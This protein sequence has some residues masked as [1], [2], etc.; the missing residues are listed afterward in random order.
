MLHR[1]ALFVVILLSAVVI[2][3]VQCLTSNPSN[4]NDPR[5]RFFAGAN[6]CITCHKDIASSYL[7]TNHYKTSGETTHD[8]LKNFINASNNK[9]YY[10][11]SALVIL[12]EKTSRFYQTYKM[13]GN[14]LRSE[15]LDIA[16]GSAEKAQT[17]AYWKNEQLFQLPLTF[18]ASRQAWTNSPGYPPRMPYFNRVILS[19]CFECHAS[20]VKKTDFQTGPLEMSEKLASSSLIFG[21]D[22]ERC[23][24]PATSHVEFHQQNPNATEAK[25]IT[26]IKTLN[27]QRQLDICAACHSGNDLDIQRSLF[28]FKPGDTLANFYFPHFGNGGSEPDVHGKQMQ[29]LQASKCF[30]QSKMTCSSCHNTHQAEEDK[31][32]IFI[33]SCNACHPSPNHKMQVAT[34][35]KNCIDC[36]MPLQVS[37][38]LDF[39]NGKERRS[40]PY[41]LRTHRIAVYP[42]GKE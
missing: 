33:A 30:Q 23:H 42:G 38:S 27:R 9:V 19:R 4:G 11:D 10:E 29:L 21:I 34:S 24:G 37:R 7:H 13:Y 17:Y 20:Y 28:A 16:I 2:F 22:C 26:V 15:P 25:F 14:V 5:G 1:K 31:L 6:S 41:L 12:E 39:N 18:F 3:F 8:G 36:H 32:E 35:G 40:I